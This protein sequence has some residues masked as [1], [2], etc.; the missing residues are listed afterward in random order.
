MQ[1]NIFALPYAYAS[2][3]L[4]LFESTKDNS[5]HQNSYNN[6]NFCSTSRQKEVENDEGK[7]HPYLPLNFDD[8]NMMAFFGETTLAMVS[9]AQY[10][11]CSVQLFF[12]EKFNRE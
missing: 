2:A 1:T 9:H 12:R 3:Y 10:F 8:W 11:E 5:C 4:L 6:K 7:Y